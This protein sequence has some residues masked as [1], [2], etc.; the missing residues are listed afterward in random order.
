MCNHH[1]RFLIGSCLQGHPLNFKLKGVKKVTDK[2][3]AREKSAARETTQALTFA[4]TQLS[5][6]T[7]A[8][9]NTLQVVW[10]FPHSNSSW[11]LH[12]CTAVLDT[13]TE[14]SLGH[15]AQQCI[16]E[17][18][19]QPRFRR[20]DMWHSKVQ[21]YTEPNSQL[22]HWNFYIG[23]LLFE[24]QLTLKETQLFSHPASTKFW[25]TGIV[26]TLAG[27]IPL[28]RSALSKCEFGHEMDLNWSIYMGI[29]WYYKNMRTWRWKDMRK[30]M[31]PQ[32]TITFV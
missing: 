31:K 18:L 7:L 15:F 1:L 2:I 24:T 22:W 28:W 27:G 25:P 32:T 17:L 16:V 8:Q 5:G 6:Q 23:V 29:W 3:S 4:L 30:R 13:F 14:L 20:F 11:K 26:N 21:F 10:M 9:P 19:S 12:Q